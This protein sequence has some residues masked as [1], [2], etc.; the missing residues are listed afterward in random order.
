VDTWDV[1]V[2][3]GRDETATRRLW[4]VGKAAESEHRPYDL[5][6]AWD[7]ARVSWSDDDRND[8]RIVLL[9]AFDG[10]DLCGAAEADF[11]LL[12]NTHVVY[13]EFFVHPS[14]QRRGAGSA[15]VETASRLAVDDGRKVMVV[16]VY[17]PVGADS[18]G[19]LFGRTLGFA[20]AIEEG[21]KVV[22]LAA[23]E[24][25][26][27]EL[28]E[29]AASHHRDY[30][31]LTWYD[32]VPEEHV[33]GYCHIN[34][35]F[36]EEAP[37]GDLDVEAEKW[38]AKR[39]REREARNLR[40]GR[41]VVSTFALAA[42]GSV[43]GL[44]EVSMNENTPWRGMQSGTLVLSGHRGHRLGLAMKIANQRAIRERFPD[45]LNLF[46]GN[47][48]VNAPMNAVNDRLGFRSVERCVEMQ[49]SL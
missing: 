9:G 34:E 30:R 3:D 17:A 22:D 4:E 26:W 28:A 21:W 1:R 35:V 41:R 49:K 5:F 6:W 44:T 27:D 10:E 29:D 42:D 18:A 23:T 47:A 40:A 48:G 45:C 25:L 16:E 31:L 43:V 38:D 12:D 46:T 36:N 37:M 2:I 24:P 13:A 14:H 33:D 20:E 15:L 19:L 7:T 8:T 11:P 32:A 39:V